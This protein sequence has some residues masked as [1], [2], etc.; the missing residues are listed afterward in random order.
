MS[1][2][3]CYHCGEVFSTTNDPNKQEGYFLNLEDVEDL[4]AEMFL[5]DDFHLMGWLKENEISKV[6]RCPRCNK[7][8][9][10]NES[11]HVTELSVILDRLLEIK[12]LYVKLKGKELEVLMNKVGLGFYHDITNMIGY[13]NKC[14]IEYMKNNK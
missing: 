6:L 7:I 12:E 5:E 3:R 1:R 9:V 2:E 4:D 14:D 10:L 13:I 11:D 8:T